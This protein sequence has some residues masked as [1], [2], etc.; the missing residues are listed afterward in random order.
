MHKYV[1]G[2]IVEVTGSELENR[3]LEVAEGRAQ[4]LNQ[5]KEAIIN[6]I[7]R[8]LDQIFRDSHL[9]TEKKRIRLA[10]SIE[11]A[12]AVFSTIRWPLAGEAIPNVG[13]SGGQV[14][15]LEARGSA[16]NHPA[17]QPIPEPVVID[18]TIVKHEHIEN[19]YDDK[20]LG[21]Q[22]QALTEK[23]DDQARTLAFELRGIKERLESL[24]TRPPLIQVAE[25][26][27]SITPSPP[28]PGSIKELLSRAAVDEDL[29]G[30]FLTGDELR[31]ASPPYEGVTSEEL[32]KLEPINPTFPD[33]LALANERDK[34][35]ELVLEQLKGNETKFPD[36]VKPQQKLDGPPPLYEQIRYELAMMAVNG[37][38]DAL[39]L[40]QEEA[41]LRGLAVLTLAHK[42]VEE[43]Q[44]M[45][46]EVARFYA[47]KFA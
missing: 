35:V 2:K 19:P 29:E 40:L 28:K 43:R 27:L 30:P 18:R 10:G 12:Q 39:V 13:S 47:L 20:W 45:E 41:K 9:V 17:P 22:L 21:P 5:A 46:K 26:V 23:I 16:G 14:A 4:A 7:D 32:Q 42:I 25:P 36:E 31:A 24:E 8:R 15:L 3:S 33:A 44:A 37:K 1:N 11:E 6:E 34:I 38:H